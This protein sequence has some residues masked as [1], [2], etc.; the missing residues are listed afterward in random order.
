MRN[1]W[2]GKSAVISMLLA[3]GCATTNVGA[4]IAAPATSLDEQE[5]AFAADFEAFLSS[6]LRRLET[7]P[8]VV[9]AVTRSGGPIFVRGF[10]R[11]DIERGIAAT[12]D[13]LFYIASSTK[14]F[15]GLTMALL[16]RKG[17]IDLDWTLAELA[18]DVAFAPE[19]RAREITLRHLLSHSHGLSNWPIQFRLAFSGEH[20]PRTLW[21]LLPQLAPNPRA[22]LGTY[23]YS[24][25]GYNIAALLVER[26]LGRR[27]QDLVEAQVLRPLGLGRTI[28]Q[29]L[30]RARATRPVAAPYL[31]LAPGG[32]ELLSL[33][34][35]DS[36]MQSA[37]G[38]YSSANDLARWLTLHLRAA[39][40]AGGLPLPADVIAATH[41]QFVTGSGG[42]D[43]F[44][45]TGYGFGWGSGPYEG[46]TLYQSFG[47]YPGARSHVS[48]MPDR[49]LG[50]AILTNDEGA[51]APF[52]DIAAAYAYEW[53]AK[54]RDAA[55][56][57]AAPMIERI[58]HQAPRIT[59][60]IAASRAAI[61]GRQ[62]QLSLDRAAYAGRFCSA[63]F[64][65]IAVS[66]QGDGF[67]V[68][69]GAMRSRAA[70]FTDPDAMRV[71]LMPNEGMPVRFVVEQGRVTALNAF[72]TTF[73]RCG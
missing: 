65:T 40:G 44:P 30:D 49:D 38:M 8:G 25:L 35:V 27:W 60:R 10:G 36:N 32:P 26:R 66:P 52:I 4:A 29:G 15:M 2:L 62:W 21:N 28:T 37:G 9:V 3:T 59:Q 18:P 47:G 58:V 54:G 69:M 22:P 61:A 70:P 19:L 48:F 23:A 17:M 46:G 1:A 51:G 24:N 34:K 11:A 5:R 71:E 64:G 7:I 16:E 55:E 39:G 31:G 53:F 57:R 42:S 14:S 67:N 50:V 68:S 73:R 13:T 43:S 33:R 41:R 72:E 63:A 12:P 20:D 6:S 45:A 56:R